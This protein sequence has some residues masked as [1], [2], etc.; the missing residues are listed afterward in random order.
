[1]LAFRELVDGYQ[2]QV[3]FLA[4][5]L[6]GNHSDAEDI[7]QEAFIKAYRYIGKFRGDAQFGTWI[8]RITVN[9]YI[10]SRRKKQV[11]TV[12][13]HESKDSK[14]QR[15]PQVQPVSPQPEPGRQLDAQMLQGQINS[16]LKQLSP[17]ERSVFVLRHYNEMPLKEIGQ[18]LDIAEGT[19]K[20]LLF[21]AVKRLQKELA[22]YRPGTGPV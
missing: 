9:C 18:T 5:D 8:Y 4:L 1:M 7:A 2:R 20:S 17:K 12:P 13:I 16:A 11:M 15:L 22:C 10:D 21:R 3:Y 14:N 19:V 6:T